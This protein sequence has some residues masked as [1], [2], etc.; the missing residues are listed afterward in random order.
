MKIDG[1]AQNP[2]DIPTDL[3]DDETKTFCVPGKHNLIHL[4]SLENRNTGL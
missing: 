4:S 1:I 3:D 2:Y